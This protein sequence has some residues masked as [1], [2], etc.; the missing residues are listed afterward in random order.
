VSETQY[1]CFSTSTGM[2]LFSNLHPT[3]PGAS[4]LCQ[5]CCQ[6]L[7]KQGKQTTRAPW[8]P[9]LKDPATGRFGFRLIFHL[10]T[11]NWKAVISPPHKE[12]CAYN[13]QEGIAQLQR[14]M[15]TDCHVRTQFFSSEGCNPQYITTKPGEVLN[16]KFPAFRTVRSKFTFIINYR[17]CFS[18]L[19]QHK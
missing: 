12:V 13:L 11:L 7:K 10:N 16:L 6:W 17:V 19:S 8:G 1:F 9:A 15:K 4:G 18:M 2:T 14:E 3:A 5:H